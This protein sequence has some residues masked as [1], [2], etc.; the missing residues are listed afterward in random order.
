MRSWPLALRAMPVA[1][2]RSPHEYEQ[3]DFSLV[4][5]NGAAARKVRRSR[6]EVA[7][8]GCARH[9]GLATT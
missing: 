8:R 2:V 3:R 9:H 6:G 4:D 5:V 1:A 7:T